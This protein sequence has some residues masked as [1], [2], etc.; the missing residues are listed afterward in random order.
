MPEVIATLAAE[1]KVLEWNKNEGVYIVI[2]G[3]GF[4]K[5]FNELRY[6][7]GK[8]V[9]PRAATN[10]PF[11]RMH[12]HFVLVRGEKWAGTGSA[13]KVKQEETVPTAKT[14]VTASDVTIELRTGSEPFSITLQ[15]FLDVTGAGELF[16]SAKYQHNYPGTENT[17]PSLSS[18]EVS[19]ASTPPHEESMLASDIQRLPILFR[20]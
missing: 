11:S 15:Q 3:P 7:R 19:E 18:F 17:D 9:D 2:D 1:G 13:F 8:K 20:S 14:A 12:T 16:E 10:R 4:E 5:R 6:V